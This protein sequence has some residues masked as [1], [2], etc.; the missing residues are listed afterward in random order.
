MP[1]SSKPWYW[2]L[3]KQWVVNING[4]RHYLGRDREEAH[5]RYHELMLDKPVLVTH[6][7]VAELCEQY[8]DWLQ[9]NRAPR[10]YEWYQERIERFL[11]VEPVIRVS[12]IRPHHVQRWLDRQTWSDGY[13]NGVVTALKRVFNWGVKQGLLATN[14]IQGLEKP[15]GNHRESPVTEDEYRIV[16]KNTF[17]QEFR[18]VVNFLWFVGCRPQELTCIGPSDLDLDRGTAVLTRE[19]SKGKKHRRVIYLPDEALEIVRR[20]DSDPL[21]LNTRGNSW[22]AYAMSCRFAKLEKKVGRKIAAYDFR[23]SYITRGL[24][25]GVDP[26]TLSKIV[27]HRD[28]TMISRV[29]SHLQDDP[30]F[31]RQQAARITG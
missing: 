25:R 14:P 9:K 17:D 20:R 7:A 30:D 29:Y 3:R 12:D 31:M 15:Q 27:G 16:L 5:R 6:G 13:K 23:H 4:K 1:R 18:D 11:N 8:M 19:D 28:V 24:K 22:T 2:K 26:V 10:T 21:F